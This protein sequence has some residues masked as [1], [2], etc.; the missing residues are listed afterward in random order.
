MY[1]NYSQLG[2]VGRKGARLL[3]SLYTAR[4]GKLYVVPIKY[5]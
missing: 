1:V 3:Q 4:T 5:L 2:G